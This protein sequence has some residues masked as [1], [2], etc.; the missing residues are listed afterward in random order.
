MSFE[1]QKKMKA[2]LVQMAGIGEG[3]NRALFQRT[4]ELARMFDLTV[5]TGARA[6]VTSDI[7]E[8]TTV[9][10]VPHSKFFVGSVLFKLYYT[11]YLIL[12]LC[13]KK[14][15]DVIYCFHRNGFTAA[16]IIKLLRRDDVTWFV[17]MQ[18]T[19]YYYWDYAQHPYLP[20]TKRLFYRLLG[21]FFIYVGKLFLPKADRVFAMSYDY[22]EGF[23]GIMEADFKVNRHCLTPIPNGVDLTLVNKCS[24]APLDPEQLIDGDSIKLI[25]AGNVRIERLRSLMVFLDRIEEAGEKATLYICGQMGKVAR[26]IL[27]TKK[28]QNIQ[29]L[30]L[31]SHDDL[32]RLYRT[33]DVCLVFIDGRMRDH[34]FSHPGKLFESLALGKLVMVSKLQ[35][36]CRNIVFDGENAVVVDNQRLGDAAN[37]LVQV[38]HN[39]TLRE[40]I[41]INAKASVEKLDWKELNQAWSHVLMKTLS[42]SNLV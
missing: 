17:D 41:E 31:I 19:P 42:N 21:C 4:K 36:V 6:V 35:S 29:Y 9:Q 15:L 38:L 22:N 5:I 32:L 26:K 27:E 24:E 2:V 25:Y 34:Q 30:G 14:D 28:V 8:L 33:V 1:K 23:A 12:A 13:R 10:R 7:A 18:H 16:G 37:K 40:K 39:S 11:I 20:L 3:K